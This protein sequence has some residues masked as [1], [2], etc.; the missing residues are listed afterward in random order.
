[1]G[2]YQIIR[3]LGS[4]AYVLD[5]VDNL[6][7]NLIFNVED[8]TPHRGILSLL[9][10]LLMLLEVLRFL[11]FLVSHSHQ[12]TLRLYWMMSSCRPLVVVSVASW[13]NGLANHNQMPLGLQKMSFVNSTLHC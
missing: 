12:R 3:K 6:G 11:N 9:V 10:F 8:L 1:M 4:N 5:L 13:Y 2:P 7:I